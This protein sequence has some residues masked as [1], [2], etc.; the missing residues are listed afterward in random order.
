MAAC[1]AVARCVSFSTWGFTDAHSWI[2]F[3]GWGAATLTDV[4]MRPKP[5]YTAVR[6]LLAE[7]D[8]AGNAVDVRSG[9]CLA[10]PGTGTQLRLRT[11]SGTA[12]QQRFTFTRIENATSMT[13]TLTDNLGRCATVAGAAVLVRPCVAGDL[14]QRYQ[15][16][17]PAVGG[18]DRRHKM[19]TMASAGAAERSCVQVKDNARTDGSLVVHDVCRTLATLPH[20]QVWH[21]AGISGHP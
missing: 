17:V 6:D 16:I 21:L 15:L 1:L 9:H 4:Q 13:Y 8:F 2:P 20:N 12:A 5:A 10:G 3:E 18:G 19:M 14:A 11:C 7:R